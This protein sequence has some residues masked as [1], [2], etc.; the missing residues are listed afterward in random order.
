[1]QICTGRARAADTER[2]R[3]SLVSQLVA[4]VVEPVEE[5]KTPGQQE[6]SGVEGAE[7][8]EKADGKGK[9]KRETGVEKDRFIFLVV[10]V[11]MNG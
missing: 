8:K 11:R 2:I 10:P 5:K 1:M 4:M 9:K 3:L 7:G 6:E